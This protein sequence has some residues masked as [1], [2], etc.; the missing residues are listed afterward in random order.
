MPTIAVS[1][2]FH[3]LKTRHVRLV[4]EAARLGDVTLLLWP[5]EL[6]RSADGHEPKFPTEE[7]RYFWDSCRYV[8]RLVDSPSSLSPTTLDLSLIKPDIWV[9]PD[10][11]RATSRRDWCDRNDIDFVVVS[12]EVLKQFP[13]AAVCPENPQSARKKV[14][15]TG[16]FDFFHTGHVRF[17]EEVDELGDLYVCVGHDENIRL[18]KGEGHPLFPANER[19]FIAGSVKF[20]KQ[21]L[22]TSGQGWL[23]AEPEIERLRPDVY[24]VN[25]DGDRPAKREYCAAHGIEYVVLKRL[26]KPGLT[27][28]TSTDLRGF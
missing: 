8:T 23:D 11:A 6:I 7:R 12:E 22:V 5:D 14:I 20:A 28:R 3:D 24:A 9:M 16:C 4:S 19:A 17:F 27:R 13:P 18:L 2:S 10:D 15:V 21:A 25:E 1:E 26:P